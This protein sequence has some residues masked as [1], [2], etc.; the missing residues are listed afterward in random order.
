MN[1]LSI[2]TIADPDTY[3]KHNAD[4]LTDVAASAFGREPFDM[5]ADVE[6]HFAHAQ[7]AQVLHVGR[8]T[9]WLCSL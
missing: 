5:A 4:V 7:T 1:E 2:R 6:S 8:S 9:V 3:F